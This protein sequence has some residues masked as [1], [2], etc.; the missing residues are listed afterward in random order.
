[1]WI[2][3]V[4][5]LQAQ[6]RTDDNPLTL[7][8]A[9]APPPPPPPPPPAPLPPSQPAQNPV[10]AF[11]Q[12]LP[13]AQAQQFYVSG[14]TTVLGWMQPSGSVASTAAPTVGPPWAPR[15]MS[16]VDATNQA[17]T[18]GAVDGNG[19]LGGT[20][21]SEAR[22][23]FGPLGATDAARGQAALERT[24]ADTGVSSQIQNDEFEIIR[25]DNGNFTI[26]LP[27]VIDLSQPHFGLDEHSQSVRDIDQT[28]FSSAVDSKVASNRYA[29][30]VR[31]YVLD[32]NN[33]IPRGANVMLV[34]HSLGG[35]TVMD[36]AADPTFNNATTGVN[37]THVVAAAYFNQPELDQVPA[38]TEVL[39][40]QNTRD[41]AVIGE[42]LG[43]TV[44]EVRNAAGRVVNGAQNTFEDGKDMVGSL[45]TGDWGGV[46]DNGG[47]IVNRAQRAL[48]PDALPM[49]DAVSLLSAGVRQV[50]GHIVEA[51]FNGGGEG[52]GHHQNNYIDYVN[53]DG[54]NDPLVS[55]FF[56]SMSKAG[57]TAPGETSA[58]DVSVNDPNFTNSYPG[59]GVVKKAESWWDH[60]PG[61]DL[62]EDAVGT[63]ADLVSDGASFVWDNRG[64]LA[65][66]RD[67]LRDGV[68]D[69]W[70]SLPGNDTVES[71]VGDAADHL[72]FNNAISAGFSALM[73]SDQ[74]TLDADATQAI[75]QDPDFLQT[76]A[77]IVNKIQ[78]LDGFGERDLTI[79][80][81]DL[82]VDLVVELGGQRGAGP[83]K[84]QL[85][86]AYD[87]SDPE[88]MKTWQVAGNELTWLL[89]HARLSGTAHVAQDGSIS[90]DYEIHDRLDLSSSTGRSDEYNIVSDVL[91]TVWH[92][93]LGAEPAAVTGSF[94][95]NATP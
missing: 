25:H 13:K 68:V 86:H 49:P 58:V 21:T 57:Y 71:W 47:D 53:G 27:G 76:E 77:D 87:L 60:V 36:L 45:L 15:T 39:V 12:G 20:F 56:D 51:R 82:N 19:D 3:V 2:N 52:A 1:M 83:M 33:G 24:L 95:R 35:D 16:E 73:G 54:M 81:A 9:P 30:M 44:T 91:G 75:Q 74:I 17:S 43:Y 37:V 50:D 70:N 10:V 79:P 85:L 80:L 41:V 93:V 22:A 6:F 78:Q 26:V 62:I 64:V 89:R 90:I 34:G 32:P 92:D 38:S 88:I 7:V 4:G 28:A 69:G 23:P 5:R 65:D 18:H 46:W 11:W 72:P 59:D 55:N 48:T 94:S 42:G 63:G 31:E 61:H 67:Y 8:Q 29:M 66:G 14:L 40:L 84:D